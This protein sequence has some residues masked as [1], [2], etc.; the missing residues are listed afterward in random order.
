MRR[1]DV[2]WIVALAEKCKGVLCWDDKYTLGNM[3][4]RYIFVIQKTQIKIQSEFF[5]YK[6]KPLGPKVILSL[7]RDDDKFVNVSY[8]GTLYATQILAHLKELNRTF[9]D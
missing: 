4:F 8:I 5:Y 9:K 7:G 1:K 6:W 2:Q 3:E